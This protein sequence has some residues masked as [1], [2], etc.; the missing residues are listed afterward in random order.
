MTMDAIGL[1]PEDR[2]ARGEAAPQAARRR[3]KPNS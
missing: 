3:S 1:V 2:R